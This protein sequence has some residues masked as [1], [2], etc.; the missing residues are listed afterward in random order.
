VVDA[1]PS[2]DASVD[3]G[4]GGL[5]SRLPTACMQCLRD[6]CSN[7]YDTAVTGTCFDGLAI[8][9]NP[10][11]ADPAFAQKCVDAVVC[12]YNSTDNC[13][14]NIV[15]GPVGC[16]CGENV[17]VDVCL[18]SFA[19]VRGNCI[20]EWTAAAGCPAGDQNCVLDKFSDGFLPSG[21]AFFTLGCM[22]DLCVTACS[23]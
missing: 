9:G 19:N 3:A 1:G 10:L 8:P 17:E 16:Y 2:V 23:N 20:P 11:A 15:R 5:D 13:A 22:N 6:N 4:G 12:S 7:Y 21:Y 18:T 14:D